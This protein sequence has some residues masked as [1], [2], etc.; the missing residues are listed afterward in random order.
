VDEKDPTTTDKP[1]LR[2][3]PE[4]LLSGMRRV[5]QLPVRPVTRNEVFVVVVA[6]QLAAHLSSAVNAAPDAGALMSSCTCEYESACRARHG[7]VS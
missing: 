3:A 7:N 4:K 6:E 5:C 2:F 1:A